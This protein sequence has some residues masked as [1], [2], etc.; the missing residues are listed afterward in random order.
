[1]SEA[2]TPPAAQG[3]ARRERAVAARRM[4]DEGVYAG[5]VIAAYSVLAW[6]R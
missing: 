6:S 5:T 2:E 1:M 4:D 3:E